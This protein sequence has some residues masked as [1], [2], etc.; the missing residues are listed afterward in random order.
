MTSA[1]GTRSLEG[2]D[3]LGM[4][5]LRQRTCVQHCATAV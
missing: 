2:L 4:R 3:C 5:R 1:V